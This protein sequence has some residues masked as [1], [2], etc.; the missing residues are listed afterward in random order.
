MIIVDVNAS[1]LFEGY[2]VANQ[3]ESQ[4]LKQW[5]PQLKKAF[6]RR[7][8]RFLT[9]LEARK[10]R[11][12]VTKREILTGVAYSLG[13]VAGGVFFFLLANIFERFSDYG[14]LIGWLL[15]VVAFLMGGGIFFYWILQLLQ[16]KPSP[17]ADPF[18]SRLISPVLPKWK[19]AIRGKLPPIIK[20]G[21]EGERRFIYELQ[22]SLDDSYYLLSGIQQRHGEDVDVTLV[23]P[24]GIWV[25]E[26]KYW[27]GT[28]RWRAGK[29]S[30]ERTYYKPGA[31]KVTEPRPV[32]QPPGEQWRRAVGDVNKTL[33]VKKPQFVG[34]HLTRAQ[35]KGGLVFT[36]RGA[37]FQID[38]G[39]PVAWGSPEWWTGQIAAVPIIPGWQES[40]SLEV[41]DALLAR[42]GEID[43]RSNRRCL[44]NHALS[45][46][47]HAE[48]ELM[49]WLH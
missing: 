12:L 7:Q 32:S 11:R 42:H 41:L 33:Q 46:V 3:A 49:V 4:L 21:D 10:K 20:D 45:L 18:N 25:F 19:A 26:V 34:R 8:Q 43:P 48:K 47:S 2:Q 44:K 23:G 31:I 40:D 6:E 24:K 28:I 36:H 35:A 15:L 1:N 27:N 13:I 5:R 38:S 22:S 17:P 16:P 29:W 9:E 39:L 37:T 14:R 30:R